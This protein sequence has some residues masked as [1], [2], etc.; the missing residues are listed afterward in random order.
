[1]LRSLNDLEIL[2]EDGNL[3]EGS[4]SEVLKVRSRL[5]GKIYALKVIDLL[6]LSPNDW[7]NLKVEIELHEKLDHP[8]I[9]KY[10]GS[11]Q[12]QNMVYI[13]LEQAKN[14]CLFY[15]IN[16]QRGIPELL[17]LRYFYQCCSAVKYLHSKRIIHRD[18]KPENLL[19]DEN[20]DIK[21]CDFGWSC[22]L[23]DEL[24][25]RM[26]IC[27]T[28]EYMAPEIVFRTPY[29]Y[30]V[31]IWCLGILL[32]EMLHGTPP[33]KAQTVDQIKEELS[34]K[35][36]HIHSHLTRYT[37][38]LLKKMLQSA[39]DERITIDDIFKHPAIQMSLPRFSEPIPK[40]VF[41][42]LLE[43]YLIN[44][45]KGKLRFIPEDLIRLGTSVEVKAKENP[46]DDSNQV[47]RLSLPEE[48]HVSSAHLTP[49]TNSL[50][51]EQPNV[52]SNKL[53]LSPSQDVKT[54]SPVE[55]SSQVVTSAPSNFPSS[56]LTMGSSVVPIYQ[57]QPIH[58]QANPAT[59]LLESSDKK[60]GIS[61]ELIY[62]KSSEPF[63]SKPSQIDSIHPIETQPVF[64]QLSNT[65]SITPEVKIPIFENNIKEPSLTNTIFVDNR[66]DRAWID[67][68]VSQTQK[69]SN[70]EVKLPPLQSPVFRVLSQTPINSS[71][72]LSTLES[73]NLS[74]PTHLSQ[75]F[76]S[77]E[78]SRTLQATQSSGLTNLSTYEPKNV[79]FKDAPIGLSHIQSPLISNNELSQI[80][81]ISSTFTPQNEPISFS[82]HV[83][84]NESMLKFDHPILT[85]H[86]NFSGPSSL[87]ETRFVDSSFLK[88]PRIEERFSGNVFSSQTYD[89]GRLNEISQVRPENHL[90]SL[91]LN[92]SAVLG[93][94]SSF[95]DSPFLSS[96]KIRISNVKPLDPE[97]SAVNSSSVFV[98]ARFSGAL[99]QP[100]ALTSFS[101]V[102]KFESSDVLAAK[103]Y[104]TTLRDSGA[105]QPQG[106]SSERYQRFISEYGA[107][108]KASYWESRKLETRV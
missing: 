25:T 34:T 52:E 59:S 41:K 10:I 108:V 83:L 99:G 77:S 16:S 2:R 24:E 107:P 73:K 8:N 17:A 51:P 62:V 37:V 11:F 78:S 47:Q 86:S 30:K 42:I 95:V 76:I 12:N 89:S 98:D 27:G 36:I 106:E 66:A 82:K 84:K 33:F 20:F 19:L 9:I 67:R 26:S 31:D 60:N 80:R 101:S 54:I 57:T 1:M 87:R 85:N 74:T 65:T 103:A 58:V 81:T 45:D 72:V 100:S 69:P 14:G 18:I 56:N 88:A 61:S 29:S 46:P 23:A 68:Y 6:K 79:I 55:A 40:E 97:P 49:Q 13:Q 28:Y 94:S 105:H 48:N 75:P 64:T 90:S 102:R 93:K 7:N 39:E 43:N 3:G 4:F 70:S 104:Q 22:S 50:T 15:Y 91:P 35:N 92:S 44:S 96:T 32:Y 53:F 63:S 21:L 5:D 71:T 38:D